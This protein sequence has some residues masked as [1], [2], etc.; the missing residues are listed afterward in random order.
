M[1]DKLMILLLKNYEKQQVLY[2]ERIAF[3][4][5]YTGYIYFRRPWTAAYIRVM[6]F[7]SHL[8]ILT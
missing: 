6:Q 1:L 7:M 5:Q 4:F 3:P 8:M 2:Y